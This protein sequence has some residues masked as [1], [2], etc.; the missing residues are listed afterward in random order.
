METMR[1]EIA[2][3]IINTIALLPGYFQKTVAQ[4]ICAVGS[5]FDV[6]RETS[7]EEMMWKI[8]TSRWE[9]Y[10][11]PDVSPECR[12]FITHDIK[13][14]LGVVELSKLDPKRTITLTDRKGTGFAQCEITMPSAEMPKVNFTVII[15]GPEQGREV[16]YTVHPGAPVKP[17]RVR[18]AE[19]PS[20]ITVEKAVQ[21]GFTTAK[22]IGE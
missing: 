20:E 15:L 17:S 7:T 5:K 2:V 19:M 4:H 18:M 12:G 1:P 6:S 11:H 9:E 3:A 16:V 13:G 10:S 8:S 14:T 22:I 21:L